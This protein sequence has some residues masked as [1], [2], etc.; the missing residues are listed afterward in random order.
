M[1]ELKDLRE[2]DLEATYRVLEILREESDG[3]NEAMF[4]DVHYKVQLAEAEL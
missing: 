2:E 4:Q 3:V 1:N